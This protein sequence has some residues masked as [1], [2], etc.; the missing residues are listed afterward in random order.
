MRG[1]LSISRVSRLGLAAYRMY[2]KLPLPVKLLIITLLLGRILWRSGDIVLV[3]TVFGL[4]AFP[5]SYASA[6]KTLKFKGYEALEG[7]IKS[8]KFLDVGAGAG[9]TS[10]Y[11]WAHGASYVK[12]VEPDPLM[13]RLL[14]LNMRMNGV[15]A[16]VVAKCAGSK[17]IKV[18]WNKGALSLEK[19][20]GISWEELLREGFDVVKVDC[21]GCEYTLEK[22]H[23]RRAPTWLIEVHGDLREFLKNILEGYNV[24][25][26]ACS[27]DSSTLK[28]LT[29]IMA[30]KAVKHDPPQASQSLSGRA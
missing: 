30:R 19:C 14:K 8:S 11:A 1:R 17:F 28:Q 15:K 24:E 23:L 9:D 26:I 10:L 3:S 18:D 7:Y 21:E 12:A 22:E 16:D 27:R 13:S 2:L 29:L 6:F 25:V 5:A 20:E 4:L